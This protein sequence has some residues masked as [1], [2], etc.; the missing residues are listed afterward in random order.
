M[1]TTLGAIS[2]V[3]VEQASEGAVEV[4]IN[5]EPRE[6]EVTRSAVECLTA[7]RHLRVTVETALELPES[8]GFGM[9]AAG[10]LSTS[11]AL[12]NLLGIDRQKAFEAAHRAE[13]DCGAGLG[14]VPALHRAGITIRDIPGL[15]PVGRVQRIEEEPD[16]LL[17]TVGPPMKTSQILDDAES[18]ARINRSGGRKV[19]RLLAEPTLSNLMRLSSEFAVETGLAQGRVLEAVR[20]SE[21][22]GKTSMVMLGNSVFAIGRTEEL[23]SI[24]RDF[25]EVRHCGV[26]NVGPRLL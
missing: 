12:A 15:P 9:S 1:C 25:G 7:G 2:D 11:V 6:A 24:L 16:V 10:A 14:D 5:G 4:S 20:A 8:Q 23:T 3:S 13:L 21:R 18:V 17:A 19:D 22:A 26:D